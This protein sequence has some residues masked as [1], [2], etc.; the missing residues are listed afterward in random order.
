M[1]GAKPTSAL[2]S[3]EDIRAFENVPL[4]S[5][6]L[7]QSTYEAL[8]HGAAIDPDAPAITYFADASQ[9]DR[10]RVWTHRAF[11]ET[12]HRTAN[13]LRR[14]GIGRNDVVAYVLPNLPETHL[15]VWGGSAAGQVLAVNPMLDPTQIEELMRA[16]GA[17]IL[18][19]VDESI[20]P[21]IHQRAIRAARNLATVLLCGNAPQS[22][23]FWEEIRGEHADGL[24][25]ET[26]RA[27]DVSTLLCTGGTTGLP[28]I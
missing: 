15:I 25:F 4:A 16:A 5:R 13:A 11:L 24:N 8:K 21:D 20:S 1:D 6:R 2:G 9:L 7:P 12:I 23:S 18:V 27:T 19:T 10:P 3:M 26:P 22:G 28:K 14:L 17:K